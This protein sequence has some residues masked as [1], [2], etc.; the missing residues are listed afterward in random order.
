MNHAPLGIFSKIVY[1]SFI[2]RWIFLSL[3]GVLVITAVE[4]KD[5]R[6]MGIFGGVVVVLSASLFGGLVATLKWTVI[7]RFLDKKDLRG[8]L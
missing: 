5:I 7:H 1:G 3:L 2:E 4:S 8:I 6:K